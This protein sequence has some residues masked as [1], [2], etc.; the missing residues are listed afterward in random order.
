MGEA[1][2]SAA[3]GF[4]INISKHFDLSGN[5]TW[6]YFVYGNLTESY[7]DSSDLMN[8]E[9]DLTFRFPNDTRA[10][11]GATLELAKKT[12]IDDG[13]RGDG[14]NIIVVIT[15]SKSVDDIAVPSIALKRSNASVFSIGVGNEYSLGQLNEIASDPNEHFVITLNSWKDVNSTFQFQLAKRFCQGKI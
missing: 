7:N 8:A 2:F 12:L 9:A 14:T 6:V 15:S 5:M 1:N 11:L 10:H 3:V 13:S 4:A